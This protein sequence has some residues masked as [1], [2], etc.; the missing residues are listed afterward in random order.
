M[1]ALRR[2]DVLGQD[3]DNKFVHFLGCDELTRVTHFRWSMFLLALQPYL[4]DGTVFACAADP[5][6]T[7]ITLPQ[8]V[9]THDLECNYGAFKTP[10]RW[11][12]E[13][14]VEQKVTGEGKL[15]AI[16][17]ANRDKR[18]ARVTEQCAAL[19]SKLAP[20]CLPGPASHWNERIFGLPVWSDLLPR[21][22]VPIDEHVRW[23]LPEV[24]VYDTWYLPHPEKVKMT[25]VIGSSSYNLNVALHAVCASIVMGNMYMQAQ[26]RYDVQTWWP[27]HFMSLD[28][29]TAWQRKDVRV[30]T[31]SP[32]RAMLPMLKAALR[33]LELHRTRLL[34]GDEA[35]F[36]M[37][38]SSDVSEF[39][40]TKFTIEF[41]TVDSF[42]GDSCELVVGALPDEFDDFSNFAREP[43]RL[44]TLC[45]RSSFTFAM[46]RIWGSPNVHGKGA[47]SLTALRD[48]MWGAQ[49]HWTSSFMLNFLDVD[50]RPVVL[51]DEW[52]AC[53]ES[54]RAT[55]RTEHVRVMQD[56]TDTISFPP[57][58]IISQRCLR[59]ALGTSNAVAKGFFMNCPL[60]FLRRVHRILS[61]MQSSYSLEDY[62]W[63][64]TVEMTAINGKS[65]HISGFRIS[66][67]RS[68]LSEAMRLHRNL[69]I[70]RLCSFIT[71]PLHTDNGVAIYSSTVTGLGSSKYYE[72]SM[73]RVEWLV[74]E[75]LN[76]VLRFLQQDFS[77][78]SSWETCWD[79]IQAYMRVHWSRIT[80][81]VIIAPHKFTFSDGAFR[82][83][84]AG[85]NGRSDFYLVAWDRH[86]SVGKVLCS[87]YHTTH[88]AKHTWLPSSNVPNPEARILFRYQ[89][90][91]ESAVHWAATSFVHSSPELDCLGE[92]GTF[93]PSTPHHTVAAESDDSYDEIS[94]SESESSMSIGEH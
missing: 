13:M 53:A 10:V 72:R 11:M 82:P 40:A 42:Q 61:F 36:P 6:Q 88:A 63:R 49:K 25:G 76:L 31:L 46:P 39:I 81:G 92:R 20:L 62:L 30:V 28:E 4:S 45:S 14:L 24:V 78:D 91:L 9:C 71:R 93:R 5:C 1:A 56:A 58:C 33:F 52:Y 83:N 68:L 74:F 77:E 17:F 26:S 67:H 21:P 50:E 27:R 75:L 57:A 37:D 29:A 19:V 85:A 47:Q 23:Y 3:G 35:V 15:E 86:K 51:Q 54:V 34:A 18:S 90:S 38:V 41:T 55:L 16:H 44:L 59:S 66:N 65:L 60:I 7:T 87:A 8:T 70:G 73:G 80:L 84:A 2:Y 79:A 64:E 48:L 43:S 69:R 32:S 89:C 22:M 94:D 12:L